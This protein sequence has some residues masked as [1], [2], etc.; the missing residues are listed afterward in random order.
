MYWNVP[1]MVPCAVRFCGVV[2]SIDSPVPA[3]AGALAFARPKSSSFAP[4]FVSMM[5]PG[6]MSRWVMTR[7][8]RLV[9]RARDLNRYRHGLLE[10]QSLAW[11]LQSRA[12][13]QPLGQR[14]ALEVL[15]HQEIDAVLT[16][17]VVE[18]ADMR[19]VQRRDGARFA[20]ESLAQIRIRSNVR[21]QDF[22]GD[23]TFEARVARFVDLAHAASAQ[24][25]NDFVRPEANTG[26]ERH[27]G[28]PELYVE[29]R[30]GR[31]QKDP[32]Y[33]VK[34]TDRDRRG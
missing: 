6:L 12:R 34:R 2:G 10:R 26:R 17:D 20:I 7:A 18:R 15:H 27:V 28:T 13:R 22:D 5:L 9:Q 4:A 16:P 30:E 14:F 24:R 8:V 19:M 23:C 1:R 31:V 3:A 25:G 33:F 21:G 29:R 11:S 32:P